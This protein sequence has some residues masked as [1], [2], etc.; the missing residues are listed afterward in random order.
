MKLMYTL[1]HTCAG[2]VLAAVCLLPACGDDGEDLPT[3]PEAVAV[4]TVEA[5]TGTIAVG[6]TLQLTATTLDA[7][8]NVLD[9]RP[10]AW[11]SA[12]EAVATV[13]EAGLVTGQGP[14]ET[15]ITAT[16]E[17]VADGVTITVS[18][19]PPPPPP[20]GSGAPGLQEVATGLAFPVGLAS[21]PGDD[22]LFIL[23]KGGTVRIVEDGQ[24]VAQPFLDLSGRVSGRA[25]QGLL[26]LAFY[27]DYAASGRF[28][29]HYTDLQ[30]DTR[31]SL[32]QVS[33]DPNR[34]DGGSESPILTL[35]QPGPAHNGGQIAF[36]PD[37][38]LYIGLGD[39]GSNEGDDQGR[40]QN[41]GDLFGSVL[42]IDVSSG[43]DYTVPPDNPF[44][45]QSG[46]RPEIWSY[47]LR[48]PWR[49]SFDPA[50]G[51]LYIADVG[52]KQWEEINVARAADGTGRGV[53]YGWSVMEGTSCVR[54]GCDQGGLT[55]PHVQYDHSQGCSVTGGY[56][57]R[58]DAIPALQGQ[59]L[60][61]D[62]CQGWVRSFP[63]EDDTPEP[64][65]WPALSP[66]DNITSFGQ[67]AA[68]ELYI[69]TSGGGVFK[70]VPE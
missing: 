27:P 20:P 36:G 2:G 31:I 11:S 21:P 54:A 9:D 6:Q 37:G 60:Y 45:S 24:V 39:G 57:Y 7:D 14:G 52:Q 66:G 33:G 15:E 13:S 44:A 10:V 51:D 32:F 48:N 61:A 46:A 47:G 56:V 18:S 23:E 43:A 26:G 17:G 28:V 69:L 12:D 1:R 40:A 38:M 16:A 3:G 5:P 8:G 41:L 59:Y 53:N 19:E 50:N 65:E 4:V 68:G 55:P 63:A 70:I 35:A 25:E 30:G 29:V 42:R 67:D 64:V 22:R 58:G 34:A 49:F 62:F